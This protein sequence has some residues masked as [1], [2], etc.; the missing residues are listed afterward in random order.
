MIIN[1]SAKEVWGRRMH[2]IGAKADE[3]DTEVIVNYERRDY[4][5]ESGYI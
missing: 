4:N 3:R 5:E 2:V 1:C